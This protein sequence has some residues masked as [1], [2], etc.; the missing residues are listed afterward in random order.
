ME[1]HRRRRNFEEVV[2][3]QKADKTLFVRSFI[4]LTMKES[5]R[6]EETGAALLE[7]PA[8]QR[9]PTDNAIVVILAELVASADHDYIVLDALDECQSQHELTEL[10]RTITEWRVGFELSP[11]L[12]VLKALDALKP[13]VMGEVCIQNAVVDADFQIYVRERKE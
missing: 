6:P 11:K 9:R 5:G 12:L 13:L 1:D 8:W 4:Q 2:C 3:S 10:I 7:L